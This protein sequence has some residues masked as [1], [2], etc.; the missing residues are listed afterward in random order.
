MKVQRNNI[1]HLGNIRLERLKKTRKVSGC[2][3]S[4]QCLN[5]GL[6]E[7]DAVSHDI[8][9]TTTKWNAIKIKEIH[10]GYT[11]MATDTFVF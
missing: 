4:M 8:W 7:Y 2:P 1:C 9:A 11:E 3:V 10:C 6:A 5:S